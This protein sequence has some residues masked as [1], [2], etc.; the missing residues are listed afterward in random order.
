MVKHIQ[1]RRRCIKYECKPLSDA[2]LAS[3]CLW[4]VWLLWLTTVF[5]LFPLCYSIKTDLKLIRFSIIN[6]RMLAQTSHFTIPLKELS[7]DRTGWCILSGNSGFIINILYV[8]EMVC[9]KWTFNEENV[10]LTICVLLEVSSSATVPAW[11][12]SAFFAFSRANSMWHSFD[13]SVENRLC[14]LDQ[15][16]CHWYQQ[17]KYQ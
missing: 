1:E 2:L 6:R 7:A 3:F 5:I 12:S 4:C 13:T 14:E 11:L 17:R 8:H 9:Y 16:N 10:M 15:M